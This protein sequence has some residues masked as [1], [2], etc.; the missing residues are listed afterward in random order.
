MLVVE[1]GLTF[2]FNLSVAYGVMPLYVVRDQVPITGNTATI[3]VKRAFT[4]AYWA[5]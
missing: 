3:D 4:R 2:R 5:P 1:V